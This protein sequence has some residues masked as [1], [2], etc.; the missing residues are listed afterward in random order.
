MSNSNNVKKGLLRAPH[1]SLLYALGLEQEDLNKP[2]IGIASSYNETIPG[3]KHLKGVVEAIKEGIYKNGGIPFEF[4]TIGICDGIAMNHEGMSYSLTSRQLICDSVVVQAKGF[5]FDGIVFVP[6]CDKVVPGMLMAAAKLNLPSIFMSGGPMLAGQVDNQ[7]TSLTTVFE[8]VGKFERNEIDEKKLEEYELNSCPTCGSCSGMY[9]ANTM[10]CLCEALGVS[11]AGNGS[12]PAVYSK[13]TRLYK[14]AG[15][16]IMKLVNDDIK[17]LDIVKRESFLNAIACDMAMTGSTN[18]VLHL[19]AIASYANIDLTLDDFDNIS[20]NVGQLTKLSPA[21]DYSIEDFENAGG[22][23]ALL[24]ELSNLKGVLYDTKTV[25]SSSLFEYIKD[26]PIKDR[27]IITSF[28]KPINQTSGLTILKGNIATKGAIIKTGALE[29]D[30][31]YFKGKAI[32]FENE[33]ECVDFLMEKTIDTNNKYVLIIRNM[34][35]KGGYGMPEMLTPTSLIKGMN[36]GKQV[37]LITDGRFSGGSNGLV[38]GHVCPEASEMGLISVIENDNLIEIDLLKKEINL[39]LD[40][41]LIEKRLA[42]VKTKIKENND[43]LDIYTKLA[44]NA[45]YGGGVNE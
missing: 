15:K 20:N 6:N 23:M 26:Y 27:N 17:F 39:L 11:L 14:Q 31:P 7:K 36:L 21:S 16:Q 40:N 8:A 32:V 37:A 33:K 45:S 43:Y 42:N 44:S 22:M 28:D 29:D 38:I 12:I 4:N 2:F 30:N 10:N 13:R 34:G 24:N 35:I 18:T 9:T 1:R 5:C 25:T 3:H 19:L 41:S